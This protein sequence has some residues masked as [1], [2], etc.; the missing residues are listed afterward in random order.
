M[1]HKDG[2]LTRPKDQLKLMR[3][4]QDTAKTMEEYK[5]HRS[6]AT[7]LIAAG[8]KKYDADDTPLMFTI[9]EVEG[10]IATGIDG[11]GRTVSD[12]KVRQNLMKL[13]N[14]FEV[15]MEQKKRLLTLWYVQRRR[16]NRK[17]EKEKKR[18]SN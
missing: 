13:L 17:K 9:C 11:S 3:T 16:K 4:G 2:Q 15:D 6:V 5:R 8:L 10:Q 1:K 18:S 12:D 14:R 7:K